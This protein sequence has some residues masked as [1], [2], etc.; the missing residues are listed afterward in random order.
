MSCWRNVL[1]TVIQHKIGQALDFDDAQS[2]C[3]SE[4]LTFLTHATHHI[5]VSV[6]MGFQ[7]DNQQP[8]G[9]DRPDVVEGRYIVTLK[10]FL[11][12]QEVADHCSAIEGHC[13]E[14]REAAAASVTDTGRSAVDS[15]FRRFTVGKKPN[16][17]EVGL[18]SVA[19]LDTFIGYSGVFPD[20]T[21]EKIRQSTEVCIQGTQ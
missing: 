5:A 6:I 7:P 20:A 13:D 17:G 10:P 19:P 2:V 18:A 14:H 11:T 15:T 1:P 16:E 3:L 9:G 21:L 8:Q 4:F 12:Q